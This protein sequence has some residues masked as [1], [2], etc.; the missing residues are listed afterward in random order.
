MVGLQAPLAF[1][2]ASTFHADLL[3]MLQKTSPHLLVLEAAATAEI[4]FTAAQLL[5]DLFTQCR[6]RNI[7]VAIA[8][9]ESLRAQD[10]F[11]RFRLYDVLP[12][13]HIFRSVDE[14]VRAL[15]GATTAGPP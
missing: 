8:R 3:A 4:D 15:G 6:E 7:D 12:R 9:L 11:E 10:A 14:A 5:L 2:N 13:D 1:L